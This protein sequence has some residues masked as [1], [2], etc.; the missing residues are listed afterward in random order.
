MYQWYGDKKSITKAYPMMQKYL[1]YLENVSNNYIIN[2]GLG[3]WYDLGPKS[4]GESQLTPKSLTATSIFFFDAKL[5]SEMAR[6]SGKKNDEIYYVNL[7]ES[8]RKAFNAKF[9]DSVSKV[10]STGSQTAYAMPLYFGMVD[11]HYRKD[12]MK[13]LVKS[14][15]DNGK[16]LTSGDIGYRYLLR[17]LEDAGQS[18]LIYDMNSRTDIPGYL[19]QISKGATSLTESW[20]A[21]KSV[22]NNHMML[23]HLM[24]WFYSGLGGIRM[25]PDSPSYEQVII[26]P[27]L[28]GNVTWAETKFSTI[29]GDF[30][31]NW[32]IVKNNIIMNIKVPVNCKAIVSI[33]QTNPQFIFENENLIKQV[34]QVKIIEVTESRTLCEISS[35]E[36]NFR[37]HLK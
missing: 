22:S 24:E 17:T 7:A 32:K 1:K 20:A 27:E 8:I 15:N 34:D 5:M 16:A 33:P 21:L 2:N 4:P 26:Y 37:A 30:S 29:H 13:N 28:V 6:I 9:F 10:Y 18:Q 3:D 12:V 35:G 23:G 25:S 11:N 36:Y 31:C 14:I 19:Y